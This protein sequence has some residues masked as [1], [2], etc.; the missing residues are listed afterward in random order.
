MVQAQVVRAAS[1]S[2]GRNLD[3]AGRD[4]ERA[5]RDVEREAEGKPL[6]TVYCGMA[7]LLLSSFHLARLLHTISK[8]QSCVF[9]VLVCS[10]LLCPAP[11]CFV[12]PRTALSCP[13][14]L[15]PAL[16]CP[17][18]PSSVLALYPHVPHC[19]RTVLLHETCED[20]C[21][22]HSVHIP[23]NMSSLPCRIHWLAAQVVS[24]QSVA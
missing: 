20:I 2:A 16:L 11:D 22:C 12:L 15:C 19:Y 8:Q 18:L 6:P 21:W 14:L 17:A 24:Q 3:R 4:V 5:G 10:A 13:A 9:N 7:A 23:F 1:S